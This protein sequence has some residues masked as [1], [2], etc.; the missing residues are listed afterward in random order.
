VGLNDDGAGEAKQVATVV[1]EAPPHALHAA[2]G[3]PLAHG[4]GAGASVVPTHHTL[5]EVGSP[6][7]HEESTCKVI[8]K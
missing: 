2:R 4:M 3:L 7:S 8:S 1:P 6:H 5:Y